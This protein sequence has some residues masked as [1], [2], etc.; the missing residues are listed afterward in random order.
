MRLS[1]LLLTAPARLPMLCTALTTGL[2]IIM[3]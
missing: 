2:D 1:L 3:A